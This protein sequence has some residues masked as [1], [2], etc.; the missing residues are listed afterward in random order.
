MELYKK[1]PDMNPVLILVPY[2]GMVKQWVEKVEKF[3]YGIKVV[4]VQ[5][6]SVSLFFCIHNNVGHHLQLLYYSK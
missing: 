1:Q 3:T 4:T 5:S 6:A 2:V